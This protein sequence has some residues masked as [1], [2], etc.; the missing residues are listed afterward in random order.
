[1]YFG[2]CC[3]DR[4]DLKVE[5]Y[6]VINTNGK[7]TVDEEEC[8]DSLTELVAVIKC[9]VVVVVVVLALDVAYIY[10]CL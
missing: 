7:V 5:H 10:I 1:M 4:F 9:F 3:D 8:F 2:Y 6:R